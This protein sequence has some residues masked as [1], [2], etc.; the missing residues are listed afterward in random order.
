MASIEMWSDASGR[1]GCGAVWDGQWFQVKWEEWPS[2]SASSIAAKELL[3][4]IVAT[5]IWGTQWEGSSVL[6][7]CD[8]ESIV[9]IVKGGYCKDPLLAHM[10][11]CLFFLEAKF[12]I[13]LSA[14]YIPGAENRAADSISRNNLSMFFN[15]LPQA[16]QDP[17]P[18]P[19]DLVRRLVIVT[20][21]T[22]ADWK[23][24]LGTLSMTP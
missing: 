21:W 19:R 17:R 8:N 22:S 18:V 15:I 7:H 24:W 23:A 9:S 13:T 12:D 2:F 20:P 16:H 6:C 1:W 14:S 3:P 5:A 11:R 4:I 10:L